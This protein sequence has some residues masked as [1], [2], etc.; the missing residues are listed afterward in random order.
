MKCLTK[1]FMIRWNWI[2]DMI[3]QISTHR[4]RIHS[5]LDIENSCRH[6]CKIQSV[7]LIQQI[8]T[9][10]LWDHSK[11]YHLKE[12]KNTSNIIILV[13]AKNTKLKLQNTNKWLYSRHYHL[14]NGKPRKRPR[15]RN[16]TH[17][18]CEDSDENKEVL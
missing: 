15:N 5:R 8:W 17:R 2:W 7:K 14:I 18:S 6:F 11:V 3:I 12:I 10:I 4:I 16:L 1:W 13:N 9:Q